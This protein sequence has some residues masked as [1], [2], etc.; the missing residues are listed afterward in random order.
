MDVFFAIPY[1]NET[2]H[3]PKKATAEL[4][5]FRK[6]GTFPTSIAPENG[7]LEGPSFPFGARPIFRGENVSFTEGRPKKNIPPQ[8]RILM[9]CFE[10]LTLH[11]VFLFDTVDGS[12]VP[13][14]HLGCIKPGK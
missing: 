5:A 3:G 7:W 12:E 8:N 14:N 1:A 9:C 13:N 4:A 2:K 6:G 10:N 11:L